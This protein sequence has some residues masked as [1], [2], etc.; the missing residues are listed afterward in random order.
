MVLKS[1]VQFLPD[2]TNISFKERIVKKGKIDQTR[3]A[4]GHKPRLA[5]VFFAH[6][7]TKRLKTRSNQQRIWNSD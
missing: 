4:T 1:Q 6:K 2:Q 7:G 3:I 5:T